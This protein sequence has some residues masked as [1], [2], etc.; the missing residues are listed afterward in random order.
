MK[1]VRHLF[2]LSLVFPFSAMA[3]NLTVGQ[4]PIAVNNV[5]SGEII[6]NGDKVQYQAWNSNTLAGKVRVVQHMAGRISVKSMNDPLM[7]KIK[8]AH[9]PHDKYQ[10]TTIVNVADATLGMSSMAKSKTEKGKKEFPYTSVI[11]DENGKVKNAWQL[12]PENSLILVLD[13]QGK[14]QFAKE[15]KLSDAENKQVVDLVSKL[16]QQ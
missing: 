13:K 6:L 3:H 9:F 8:A 5:Q 2:M 11:V 4:A 7:D 1:R 10:T 12:Q 14:V 16:I 15:G